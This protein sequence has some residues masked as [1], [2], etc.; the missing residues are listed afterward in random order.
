MFRDETGRALAEQALRDSGRRFRTLV[1]NLHD[2]AIF[3]I[4]PDRVIT[5]WSDGAERV[6]GYTAEE[7][8]G[9][10]LDMFYPPEELAAGEPKNE[11]DEAAASGRA[12]RE[13][14]RLTKRGVR[15]WINE[16]A[17]ALYGRQGQAHR[18]HQDQSRPHG[19]QAR[20]RRLARG[21]SSQG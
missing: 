1:Q 21:R 10:R 15:I 18:L 13:G 3:M 17:T 4:S 14:W 9:R 2:Y 11:L 19:A 5:Q 16:I 8:I 12:E 7:V 6:S 20:G